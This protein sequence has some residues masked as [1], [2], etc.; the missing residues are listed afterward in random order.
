MLLIATK[1]MLDA[2]KGFPF[3]PA[4]PKESQALPVRGRPWPWSVKRPSCKGWLA[5]TLSTTAWTNR[6]NWLLQILSWDGRWVSGWHLITGSDNLTPLGQRTT[7][8]VLTQ[9][10]FSGWKIFSFWTRPVHVFSSLI[11]AQLLWCFLRCRSRGAVAGSRRSNKHPNRGEL[12]DPIPQRRL[13]VEI[14]VS[15]G[16]DASTQ[17]ERI[18]RQQWPVCGVEQI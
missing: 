13:S 4:A 7:T 1:A 8:L 17:S 12:G 11:Q 18:G 15:G 6:P 10:L 9:Q 5:V 2:K 3:R 16:E 14:N